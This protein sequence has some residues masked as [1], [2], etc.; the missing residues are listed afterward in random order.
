MRIILFFLISLLLIGCVNSN[1]NVNAPTGWRIADKEDSIDDWA[2]FDSPNKIVNDFN[3]DGYKD[4]A[5]ILLNKDSSTG[6]KFVVEIGGIEKSQQFTLIE[7]NE[8]SPQ[9]V[10]IELLKPSDK[11]WDSACSK[12]YWDCEIGEI[13]QFKIRKPSIQFCYIESA[14]TVFLWSDRNYNFTEIPISD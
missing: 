10:A 14:C 9:S 12:G 3:G 6:F 5:Q 13:R 4:I 7:N 8:I 11:V 1:K 2:R